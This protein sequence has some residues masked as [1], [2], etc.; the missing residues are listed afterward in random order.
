MV[1]FVFSL[2]LPECKK[3]QQKNPEVYNSQMDLTFSVILVLY[4]NSYI[5]AAEVCKYYI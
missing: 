4:I 3:K 1:Y 5:Y 2:E